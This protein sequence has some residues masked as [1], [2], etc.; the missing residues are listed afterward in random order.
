MRT[1]LNF[2][3]RIKFLQIDYADLSNGIKLGSAFHGEKI[4]NYRSLKTSCVVIEHRI[5]QSIPDWIMQKISFWEQ[6]PSI[7]LLM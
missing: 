7:H 2:F 1:H 6:L 3:Y 4:R 5:M